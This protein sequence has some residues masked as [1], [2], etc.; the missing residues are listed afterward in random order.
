MGPMA[1]FLA[2]VEALIGDPAEKAAYASD[3]GG[4]LAA[5][6]FAAFDD[7]DIRTALAHS[8]DT[9]P[10]RLAAV[11]DPAAGLDHLTEVDL[12][13]LG[14]AG[15]DDFSAPLPSDL[16]EVGGAGPDGDGGHDDLASIAP[17]DG[18]AGVGLEPDEHAAPADDGDTGDGGDSDNGHALGRF[19][20]DVDIDAFLPDHGP[21]D[22]EAAP[23]PAPLLD[24]GLG[25]VGLDDGAHDA[26]A[27]ADAAGPAPADGPELGVAED[28]GPPGADAFDA[29][30]PDPFNDPF[31]DPG[32]H[33][34]DNAPW[35]DGGD[36]SADLDQPDEPDD[37]ILDDVDEHMGR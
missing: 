24:G 2:L 35:M 10:P 6:G 30:A 13:H 4:Y 27:S 21:G 32:L 8:A 5:H 1:T 11:I 9:F 12:G 18:H 28:L 25:P 31:A 34:D 29:G 17:A 33:F 20:Q 37:D 7:D 26:L 16:G 3:P 22:D 19:H 36:T 15:I 23:H 14:L